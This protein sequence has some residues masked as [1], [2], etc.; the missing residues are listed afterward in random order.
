VIQSNSSHIFLSHE[1]RIHL[2]KHFS[3]IP[4]DYK[5]NLIRTT[6]FSEEII[7]QMLNSS[8]SKFFSS[9][10]NNPD[11]LFVKITELLDK[12]IEK[13]NSESSKSEYTITLNT[14]DYPEGIGTDNLV[15][16]SELSKRQIMDIKTEIINGFVVNILFTIPCNTWTLNIITGTKESGDMYLITSFPGKWAPPF[17]SVFPQAGVEHQ[18]SLKFWE[19]HVFIRETGIPG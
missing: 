5:Q 6:G 7:K 15:H 18:D 14:G 19:E 1:T 3:V 8:G 16:K 10:A 11:E 2:L 4:E 13:K 9:F 12:G 17:P